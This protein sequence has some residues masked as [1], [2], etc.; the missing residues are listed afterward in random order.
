[1]KQTNFV[2]FIRS[3]VFAFVA[4]LQLH[5]LVRLVQLVGYTMIAWNI[6]AR[7]NQLSPV[8]L[9]K[10]FKWYVTLQKLAIIFHFFISISKNFSI[11]QFLTSLS[12]SNI[13]SC[14]HVRLSF[15]ML[16]WTTSLLKKKDFDRLR[17][18]TVIHPIP[19]LT[20]VWQNLLRANFPSSCER[21]R[22]H[23]LGPSDI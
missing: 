12:L 3:L 5:L 15:V 21:E 20:P 16:L 10:N 4:Q 14:N 17:S 2:Y 18:S 9:I 7:S 1:M 11:D 23:P 6:I 19:I 22:Y 8:A 13:Y